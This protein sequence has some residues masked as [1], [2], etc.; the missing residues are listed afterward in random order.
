MGV[1]ARALE[2]PIEFTD[3]DGEAIKFDTELEFPTL[4]INTPKT[5]KYLAKVAKERGVKFEYGNITPD[6]LEALEG[7]IINAAGIGAETFDRSS[8]AA[9]F[10]GHTFILK[11]STGV[12]MPTEA[13]SVDDLIMM[14]RED[15][16]VV[17]GALYRENP[18]RPVPEEDEAEE[19]FTRLTALFHSSE[20]LVEGLDPD[21]IAKSEVLMHSAGYR[22]EL[23]D[24]GI[25]VAPDE[26]NQRLLHAYGFGGIGWSVGPHFAQKIAEEAQKIH[27]ALLN[28]KE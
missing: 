28:S 21:L 13:V 14:P 3:P 16:T 8:E 10:K 4:S 12:S 18:D 22:V 2:E 24:Q 1:Q 19:L 15:G 9:Y 25:R 11:P 7:V 5:V 17:C 23:G 20:G 27:R 26:E 6:Q